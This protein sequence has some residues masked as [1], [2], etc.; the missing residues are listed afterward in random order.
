MPSVDPTGASSIFN[1]ESTR[2][3]G[4]SQPLKQGDT[5]PAAAVEGVNAPR[6]VG[7]YRVMDRIGR[8]GM[9]TVYRAHD[10]SID[11][12]IA[13]KFLHAAYCQEEEYRGRFLREARAAG[14]LSHPNIVTV[15][16]VGEISGRPYMAMELLE[17]EPLSDLM[18]RAGPMPITDAISVGIQL[19]HAL[20]YAHRKGIVHRDIKPS[21]I[22][23]V[24]GT[25]TVKVTDFGIAHV[26]SNSDMN[27]TRA[28]AVLGTPQYMSPE[29]TRGEKVDGRSDLFSVGIIL[30]Q[31]LSGRPPFEGDS[32]VALAMAIASAEPAPIQ[33]QRNDVPLS[34]RRIA[35]R[36]LAKQPDRRFQSGQAL[37]DALIQVQRDIDE[38]AREKG[39]VRFLSLRVKWALTMAVIV[40][41]VMAVTGTVVNRQQ[42]AA[43]M[44]QV[45]DYGASLSRFIAAQNSLSAL[46]DEWAAVDVSVQEIMKTGDFS[47]ITVIDRGGVIRSSSDAAGVGQPY[48]PRTGEP[49]GDRHGGVA[50][51]RYVDDDDNVL[52]FDAPMTFQGKS[53]GRVVLGI[54]EKP[55]AR[56]ARLS[57]SLMAVLVVVTVLAV[58]VAMYFVANWF[59]RPIKLLTQSISELSQGRLEHRIREERKDE[60]GQLFQAF[61]DMAQSLQQRYMPAAVPPP[62]V[63]IAE[64]PDEKRNV[65][66][67]DR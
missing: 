16:D 17:G 4:D 6:Q 51:T 36:C 10:P 55:L 65:Q 13:I 50:V 61:D 35:E 7:R 3:V 46:A 37:A 67:M 38:E 66:A 48:K 24:Q 9:A 19:A 63:P 11:R 49:L 25:Q 43:L 56:V 1:D 18:R 8:G 33:K 39:R 54:P 2:V 34:L 64:P 15:H 53:V 29:Q 23:C 52:S 26:T 28:G 21:N 32:I 22:M 40:F 5:L 58:A 30:Y 31:M 57:L 62:S 60:F 44:G 27:Q 14:G 20:D 41:A 47:S 12:P 42:S 59:A 45:T